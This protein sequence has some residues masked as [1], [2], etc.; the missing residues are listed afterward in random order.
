MLR[1]LATFTVPRVDFLFLS[2][3]ANIGADVTTRI[4]RFIE[5]ANTS[6]DCAIYDLRHV[7]V[8]A[9]LRGAVRRGCRL[10]IAYGAGE[11]KK[12]RPGA[13][14]KP[15]GTA[16]AIDAFGL[17]DYA[18]AVRRTSKSYLHHK[19]II[20]DG[21]AIWTGSGNFTV[22]AMELQDNNFLIVRSPQLAAR[23]LNVFELLWT[24]PRK[25]VTVPQTLV[26]RVVGDVT[27][28]QIRPFFE[29]ADG[30]HIEIA[31]AAAISRAHKIRIAAFE[32]SDH[33]ILRALAT[34]A[35]PSANIRGIYDVNGMRGAVARLKTL[36]PKDVLV[37]SGRRSV[38][39]R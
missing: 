28:A 19:F 30:K 13:D 17:G 36:D 4:V 34:F 38:C 12:L 7:E 24:Q 14:P 31:I 33:D 3:R 35:D 20:R 8:L 39:G 9:A 15:S 16:E 18:K 29:P 5:H 6:I 32:M 26:G 11:T 22:G 1:R 37:V 21:R 10:R 2:R 25:T 27:S 23:Y